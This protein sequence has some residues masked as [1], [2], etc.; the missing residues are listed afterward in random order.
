[1]LENLCNSQDMNSLEFGLFYY[2][3]FCE[4]LNLVGDMV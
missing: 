3:A 4:Y 1:M 2:L